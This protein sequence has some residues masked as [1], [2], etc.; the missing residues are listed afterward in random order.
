LNQAAI[1]QWDSFACDEC[2]IE[3][4]TG[5]ESERSLESGDILSSK[6][7]FFGRKELKVDAIVLRW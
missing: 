4:T 6:T 7:Y 3:L 2:H 5:I 1:L